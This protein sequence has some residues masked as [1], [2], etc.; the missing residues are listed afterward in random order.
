MQTANSLHFTGTR[1]SLFFFIVALSAL[2]LFSATGS[3]VSDFVTEGR[4][5]AD[6]IVLQLSVSNGTVIDQI[7]GPQPRSRAAESIVTA[8]GVLW[9]ASSF[10]WVYT[11]LAWR[12]FMKERKKTAQAFRAFLATFVLEVLGILTWPVHV[13][14][15]S[16]AFA[17]FQ[18]LLAGYVCL[19][20]I[21]E[22]WPAKS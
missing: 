20:V 1:R 7:L 8:S 14:P 21:R 16:Y 5:T 18:F 11:F 9:L 12:E 3:L 6:N 4:L 2:A 13:D 10:A 17:L 19:P 15:M 22:F